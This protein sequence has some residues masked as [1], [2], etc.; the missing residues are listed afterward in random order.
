MNTGQTDIHNSSGN[1][2][3]LQGCTLNTAR[4]Q[5]TDRKQDSGQQTKLNNLPTLSTNAYEKIHFL[6]DPIGNRLRIVRG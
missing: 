6:S 5:E 1:S 4:F 3:I 2:R